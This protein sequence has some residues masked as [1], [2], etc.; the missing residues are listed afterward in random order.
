MKNPPRKQYRLRNH[1]TLNHDPS[2]SIRRTPTNKENSGLKNLNQ[3]SI[4]KNQPKSETDSGLWKTVKSKR[5]CQTS[6]F[7]TRHKHS[8]NKKIKKQKTQNHLSKKKENWTEEEDQIL[9]SL[10]HKF[11]PKNWTEIA[12]HFQSR[13]GKQ[14]RERWYNHL[15]PEVKK[16]KW[17]EQ[18]DF[19]LLQAYQEYGSRWSIISSFLPGRTDNSIKNHFNSTIKRKMKNNELVCIST[20]KKKKGEFDFLENKKTTEN[21]KIE[22]FEK[23]KKEEN[24]KKSMT[25]FENLVE[26]K[27]PSSPSIDYQMINKSDEKSRESHV[28]RLKF[29]IPIIN[30][31]SAQN[32]ATIGGCNEDMR[33][34]QRNDDSDMK[35]TVIPFADFLGTLSHFPVESIQF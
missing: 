25:F 10:V 22:K 31:R 8:K 5:N 3:F 19:I 7:K 4:K 30:W 20:P 26:L 13:L 9:L 16:T 14:C 12:T 17:T 24:S 21:E 18:E 23:I 33:T 34:E 35:P 15:D 28:N 2:E 29:R 6:I 1:K 32:V 11:G 27:N